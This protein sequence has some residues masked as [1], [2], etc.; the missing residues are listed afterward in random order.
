MFFGK[1]RWEIKQNRHGGVY[2]PGNK[3]INRSMRLTEKSAINHIKKRWKIDKDPSKIYIFVKE[4]L[5]TQS[6]RKYASWY[7]S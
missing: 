2:D 7:R 4:K 6:D 5:R 1:N 3:N